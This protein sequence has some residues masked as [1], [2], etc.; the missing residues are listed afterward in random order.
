MVLK[1]LRK[2]SGKRYL[3]PLWLIMDPLIYSLIYLFVFTVLRARIDPGSI[4]IGITLYGVLSSSLVA[5]IESISEINGGLKCE[6]VSTSVLT[7]AALVHRSIDVMLRTVPTSIVLVIGFQVAVIGAVSYLIIAQIMGQLIMGLGFFLSPSI[8]RIPDITALIKYALRIGFYSSPTMI[9][10]ER[11]TDF[12]L[13][14][15]LNEYNP[16]SYFVELIRQFSGF[17]SEFSNLSIEIFYMILLILF[18]STVVGIRRL[19][20]LRWRMTTWS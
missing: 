15:A 8:S 5:G 6:R 14:Y 17:P 10:M 2:A 1:K 13:L 20:L 19:D 7:R 3:G 9:P 12:P 11:M 18:T 4:F 16:F